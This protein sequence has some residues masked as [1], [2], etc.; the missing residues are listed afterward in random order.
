MA[1]HEGDTQQHLKLAID[2]VYQQQITIRE[3]DSMLA[4]LRSREMPMKYKFT[5]YDHYKTTDDEIYSPAFYTSPGGYKMCISVR[6][7]GYKKGYG[8]HVSIF[9]YLMKGENDDHLP[10]PF[11]GTVTIKLLNQLK[12]KNHY[13][14]TIPFPP[15]EACSQQIENEDRAINALG[16]PN[17][18]SHSA[19]GYNADKN[20]QYLKDDCL[21]F[22]INVDTE[23]STKPWLV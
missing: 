15:N 18:I 5:A 10:W 3:Q 7:N 23:G 8:T 21:Y 20:C 6:A 22:R 12:D 11:T 17:Y 1:E 2:T 19:L 14:Q 4:R 16:H 9:A 13:S